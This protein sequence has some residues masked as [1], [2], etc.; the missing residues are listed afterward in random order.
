MLI[1]DRAGIE[2][3]TGMERDKE[4]ELKDS[5]SEAAFSRFQK[6]LDKPEVEDVVVEEEEKD[7]EEQEEPIGLMARRT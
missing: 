6:E 2:Y 4:I 5:A 7:K 3:T 1:G